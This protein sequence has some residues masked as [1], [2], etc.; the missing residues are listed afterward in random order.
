M[1]GTQKKEG[2]G[3]TFSIPA[4]PSVS[5]TGTGYTD[6]GGSSHIRQVFVPLFGAVAEQLFILYRI[7]PHI[8][9]SNSFV[10]FSNPRGFHYMFS[11]FPPSPNANNCPSSNSIYESVFL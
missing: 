6:L 3:G 5:E 1:R 10:H 11:D 4:H 2:G 7:A 8:S 9:M